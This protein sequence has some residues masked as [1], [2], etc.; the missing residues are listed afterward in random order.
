MVLAAALRKARGPV[1]ARIAEELLAIQDFHGASGT[2]S[3][4]P[5]GDVVQYPRAYIV[6]EGRLMLF[7]D[8]LDLTRRKQEA[9]ETPH[10]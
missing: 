3:F 8:Y 9:S 4:D 7:R 2:L 10:P 5:E 6:H 1:P